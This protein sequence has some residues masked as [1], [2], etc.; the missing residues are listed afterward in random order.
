VK[1]RILTPAIEDLASGRT[2][3]DHQS[4]GVGDYFFDSLFADI[5][6]LVLYGGTHPIR[7]GH[8]RMLARRFPHAIYYKIANEEVTVHR[9]I[10]CRRDPKWI[11]RQLKRPS[12]P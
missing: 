5:D 1:L 8:Y 7:H 12:A 10:D 4:P 6:S 2:F 9:I 11:Q 3:Y